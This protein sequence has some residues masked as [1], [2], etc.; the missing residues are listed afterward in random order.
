MY[1]IEVKKKKKKK[2]RHPKVS[3]FALMLVG[4]Y[5]NYFGSWQT[6]FLT[7]DHDPDLGL[8]CSAWNSHLLWPLW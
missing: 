2:E 4:N 1:I 7:H 6:K 5:F 3:K 8:N